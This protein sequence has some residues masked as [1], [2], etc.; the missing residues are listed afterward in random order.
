[1]KDFFKK[2]MEAAYPKYSKEYETKKCMKNLYQ[3]LKK[4]ILVMSI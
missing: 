4:K 2:K 3:C 1:M